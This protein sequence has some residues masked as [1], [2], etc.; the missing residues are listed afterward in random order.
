MKL[1]M[2]QYFEDSL[3]KRETYKC[4]LRSV[5]VALT[6]ITAGCVANREDLV[7]SGHVTLQKYRTGKVYIAW[8]DAY[9]DGNELLIT[10]VL[11]RHDT[12]GLPIKAQVNVTVIS[13]DG[14]VINEG[15]SSG[16]YVPRR[17]VGRYQSFK[18]FNVRFSDVPPRRSSIRVVAKIATN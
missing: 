10:G 1:H 17:M 18:R 11:R 8:C 2:E 4:L 6:V 13:P 14:K 15:R 9:E 5:M 7:E 12:V 3:I 16:I